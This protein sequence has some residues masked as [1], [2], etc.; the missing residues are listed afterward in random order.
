MNGSPYATGLVA[1]FGYDA[2]LGDYVDLTSLFQLGAGIVG[3]RYEVVSNVQRLP[4]SRNCGLFPDLGTFKRW[5]RPDVLNDRT[6]DPE[7][8]FVRRRVYFS[9]LGGFADVFPNVTMTQRRWVSPLSSI[10]RRFVSLIIHPLVHALTCNAIT[11]QLL[12]STCQ[13]VEL[14]EQSAGGA[15]GGDEAK[16]A[17]SK[18]ILELIQS[19]V[20]PVLPVGTS[21]RKLFE[22]AW[23]VLLDSVDAFAAYQSVSSLMPKLAVPLTGLMHRALSHLCSEDNFDSF[24]ESEVVHRILHAAAVL[25]YGPEYVLREH[26][27]SWLES[28]EFMSG[29]EVHREAVSQVLEAVR[30]QLRA[31]GEGHEVPESDLE[32]ATEDVGEWWRPGQMDQTGSDRARAQ[33]VDAILELWGS[34]TSGEAIGSEVDRA[35]RWIRERFRELAGF[36]LERA[37]SVQEKTLGEVR[38]PGQLGL[39][40]PELDRRQREYSDGISLSRILRAWYDD[41]TEIETRWEWEEA[42]E[43]V[44]EMVLIRFFGMQW[45]GQAALSQASKLGVTS[46]RDLDREAGPSYEQRGACKVEFLEEMAK[47]ERR[48]KVCVLMALGISESD[49]RWPNSDYGDVLPQ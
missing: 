1:E 48:L 46:V 43:L 44:P 28:V 39:Y 25:C 33:A 26:Q 23:G 32:A 20:E 21:A 16:E 34:E 27:P 36:A 31:K 7:E 6:S 45:I 37:K 47:I 30:R 11:P 3:D 5:V 41:I 22:E 13:V 19:P 12:A 29:K 35:E 17:M 38:L 24:N 40:F 49:K 2:F 4:E 42:W 18:G 14:A 15:L 8:R 9:S 10:H